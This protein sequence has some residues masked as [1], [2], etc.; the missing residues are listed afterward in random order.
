MSSSLLVLSIVALA[1][2]SAEVR[3]LHSTKLCPSCLPEPLEPDY[4]QAP[5]RAQEPP[6]F[7]PSDHADGGRAF[8]D[9]AVR[10]GKVL[11]IENA[12]AGA[13]MEGWTC[14]K[15]ATELPGAKMRREYDWESN[16]E[17]QNL[18]RMGDQRWMQAKQTGNDGKER[19]SQDPDSPPFAPY[20]W[21]VREHDSTNVGD[22]KTIR[23]VRNLIEQSRPTPVSPRNKDALFGNAE[24]WLGAKGTGARAHMDSHCIC[25]LSVVL[26]GQRRWRIGP[27]PRMPKGGGRTKPREVVFDDGVAYRLGWE[28]LYQFTLE[29]GEGVLFPPGWIHETFNTADTC[30]SALTTQLS[31]PIPA[32]YFREYYSRTRRVGDLEPC[33]RQIVSMGKDGKKLMQADQNGDGSVTEQERD[34]RGISEAAFDFYDETGGREVHVAKA[35]QLMSSWKATE[36]AVKAERPVDPHRLKFDMGLGPEKSKGRSEL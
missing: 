24:F 17:D 21:G 31:Y 11:I 16:P 25:T 10:A 35:G 15:L 32:G 7:R 28:P 12:T 3:Q 9:A 33:W 20:Y 14:E 34:D 6:R 36:T 23:K 26:S 30:T 8:F 13:A 1:T 4:W 18:Q 27:P 22:S 2:G 29:A 5:V 19:L